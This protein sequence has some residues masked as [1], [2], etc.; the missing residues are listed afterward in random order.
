MT[1]QALK[2]YLLSLKFGG[3]AV[4][5]S[6]EIVDAAVEGAFGKVWEAHIWKIGTRVNNSLATVAGQEF[7]KMPDNMSGIG[8]IGVIKSTTFQKV[9]IMGD[10]NFDHEFPYP[11]AHSSDMPTH[12]KLVY[13]S[14]ATNDKWRLYWFPVPDAVYTIRMSYRISA[15]EEF[16][17]HLPKHMIESVMLAGTALI[18]P[19]GPNQNNQMAAADASLNRAIAS[20]TKFSGGIDNI[21]GDPGWDD[22]SNES[23]GGSIW[24]PHS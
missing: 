2:S 20:D 8:N 11:A 16:L 19:P 10:S 4:P 14:D 18:L 22:F 21:G 12:A 13:H 17:P 9:N 23:S 1:L 24:D 6:R 5:Q 15:D 3:V 7:T